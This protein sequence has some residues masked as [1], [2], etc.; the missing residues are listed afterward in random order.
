M[1]REL[2]LAATMIHT[3]IDFSKLHSSHIESRKK[4]LSVCH[5]TVAI[6]YRQQCNAKRSD[7]RF[8]DAINHV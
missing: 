3:V 7:S 5:T 4:L 2:V 1:E 6:T 8:L